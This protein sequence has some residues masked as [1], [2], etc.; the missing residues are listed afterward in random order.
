MKPKIGN[1]Y[2]INYE[3][4][5]FD[6]EIVLINNV[7]N[8]YAYFEFDGKQ[9]YSEYK[10]FESIDN[11][12]EFDFYELVDAERLKQDQKW[13]LQ[14]HDW[15]T[16]ATILTEECGEVSKASLE[17]YFDNIGLDELENE[18]IQVAAVA[19]AIWEHIQEVKN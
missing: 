16:W 15:C 17:N 12:I 14:R 13:G 1:F 18:L 2:V 3:G 11:D 6:G 5:F 4:A 19:K 9:C 7:D 10:N 8:K